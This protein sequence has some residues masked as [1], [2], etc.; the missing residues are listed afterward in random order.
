M[1]EARLRSSALDRGPADLPLCLAP[2]QGR[3]LEPRAERDQRSIVAAAGAVD[4]VSSSQFFTRLN[5]ACSKMLA[6]TRKA[7]AIPRAPAASLQQAWAGMLARTATYA[8]DCV[9]LARNHG[10][11]DLTTWNN[12]LNTMNQA[13][14]TWNA[15]V[16]ATR[17]GP[18]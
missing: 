11:Q 5:D 13:S 16:A 15:A 1:A 10:S 3:A 7:Q 9:T 6:D 17:N 18:H 4:G 12:S 8:S 2:R 14:G